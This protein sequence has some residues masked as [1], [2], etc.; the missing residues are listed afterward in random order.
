VPASRFEGQVALVT[1]GGSGIG[2]AVCRALGGEGASVAVVD[3]VEESARETAAALE[4]AIAVRADVTVEEEVDAVFARVVAELGPV[5]VLANVAGWF[6]DAPLDR[7]A[8]EVTPEMT[9]EEWRH[10]LAVNLDSV[11]LCTRA[12]LRIMI[13]RGRGAIVSVSSMNG[14][15]GLPGYA[16]YSAAKSGILG[17]T[18][19]VAKEVVRS[20]IRVN[21]VAPGP[22]DTPAS[23]RNVRGDG[24]KFPL[25]RRATADE[26]AACVLFLASSDA[27]YVTGETLQVNGG[28][29]TI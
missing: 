29:L 18:R 28:M 17:F 5:D 1:G 20:G 6:A 16:H 22:V 13:P 11:F 19:A 4:R 8:V 27:S 10:M 24:S 7:P 9:V 3:V 14:V 15:D 12:A 2:R 25:G 26:I 21:A 23:R